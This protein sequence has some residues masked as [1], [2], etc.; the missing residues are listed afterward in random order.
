MIHK[1]DLLKKD[2][3]IGELLITFQRDGYDTTKKTFLKPELIL[4]C[5]QQNIQTTKDEA[6]AIDAWYSK[7][8]DMLHILYGRGYIDKGK[9]S[10]P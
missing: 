10:H 5:K 6:I 7:P 8:K 1:L 4:L 2:Y 9:V 3:T